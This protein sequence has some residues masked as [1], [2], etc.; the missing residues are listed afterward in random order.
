MNGQMFELTLA[1][2]YTDPLF[3]NRFILNSV[4]ALKDCELTDSERNELFKIDKPGLLMASHS[5]LHKRKKRFSKQTFLKKLF[6][7]VRVKLF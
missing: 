6:K 5:F 7:K 1:R 2:L 4:E 3:R